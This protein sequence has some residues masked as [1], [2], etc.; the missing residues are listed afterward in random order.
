MDIDTFKTIGILFLG[1]V[2]GTLFFKLTNK[3]K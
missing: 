1:F 2:F 3:D